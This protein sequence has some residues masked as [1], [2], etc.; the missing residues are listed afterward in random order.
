MPLAVLFAIL[1]SLNSVANVDGHI[2][3]HILFMLPKYKDDTFNDCQFFERVLFDEVLKEWRRNYGSTRKPDYRPLCTY[4]RKYVRGK[5]R[6][7]F[8]LH[9][10]NPSLSDNGM[11]DVAFYVLKYMMKP[12][13]RAIRLRQALQLNLSQEEFEDVWKVVKPRHFESEALGLG[14]SAC[15]KMPFRKRYIGSPVI[16][17]HLK[18]GVALSKKMDE[19]IPSF[20]SLIDGSSH[21]LAKYYKNNPDVFSMQDYF[22]FFYAQKNIGSDN[23]VVKDYVHGSQLIKR[24]DDF[25]KKVRHLDERLISTDLDDLFE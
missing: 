5:L 17:E 18:K 24:V 13:N 12:S 10:V 21:P 9:Y 6:T 20:F 7:N 19:P 11:A 1:E 15:Q 8:D 2:H 22:D 3:F 23:V 4:V 14:T 25:E 16:L